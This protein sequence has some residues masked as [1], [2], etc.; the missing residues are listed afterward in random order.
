MVL[1]VASLQQFDFIEA[2]IC[3]KC[4]YPCCPGSTR[5]H[6]AIFYILAGDTRVSEMRR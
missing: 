5:L 4:A 6:P 2:I 3:L 1:N